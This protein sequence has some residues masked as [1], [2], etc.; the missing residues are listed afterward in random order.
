MTMSISAT[1]LTFNDSTTQTSSGRTFVPGM[2]NKWTAP[3]RA[4]GTTYTNSTGYPIAICMTIANSG[5]N[6]NSF[7]INGTLTMNPYYQGSSGSHMVNAIIP[8]GSTYSLAAG[9]TIA[10]WYELRN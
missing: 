9:N 7:Y 3:S 4:A 6:F 1:T 2:A 8:N 5:S 10:T